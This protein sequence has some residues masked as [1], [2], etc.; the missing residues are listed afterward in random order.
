MRS[1]ARGGLAITHWQPEALA[2]PSKQWKMQLWPR[3]WTPQLLL[4]DLLLVLLLHVLGTAHGCS[5]CPARS[6]V[7][8]TSRSPRYVPDPVERLTTWEAMRAF[9]AT[10]LDWV[11]TT[12]ATFI[13]EAH[14]SGMTTVT[15]AMNAN[16]P[17]P[18]GSVLIGT[19][20][21]GRVKN[22]HNQSLSAPWM[23]P[24]QFKPG[25]PNYGCVNAP[26][27]R[28]IAFSYA[29]SLLAAGGDALQHDDP[30]MNG[31]VVSWAQGNLSGSGCYCD[32]CMAKFTKQM[33]ATLNASERHAFGVYDQTWSYRSWLLAR[34]V[35][36]PD[37]QPDNSALREVRRRPSVAAPMRRRGQLLTTFWHCTAI[38]RIPAR[39]NRGLR[40]CSPG[41]PASENERTSEA[42]HY[43][44]RE[45]RWLVAHALSTFR[46]RYGGARDARCVTEW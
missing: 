31:E 10:R 5:R 12:N 38:R 21:I 19:H 25:S 27:Y 28:S 2:L 34:D 16:L 20:T 4:L 39:V 7:V 40:S 22:I 43:T 18:G 8:F 11:Y 23:P 15:P 37:Q 13:E 9:N 30:A 14:T 1:P 35:A 17:D 44:L 36:A 26:E 3:P 29:D 41:A 46:L 33:L 32:H 42:Q 24:G 6:D 45:Q